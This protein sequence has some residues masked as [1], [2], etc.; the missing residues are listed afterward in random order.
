MKTNN[1][2]EV[3]RIFWN[4]EDHEGLFTKKKSCVYIREI[5]RVF[6]NDFFNDNL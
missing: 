1:N 6:F 4:G 2:K 5:T 3:L